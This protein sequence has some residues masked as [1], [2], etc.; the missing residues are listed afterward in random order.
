MNE[1]HFQLLLSQTETPYRA[2]ARAMVMLMAR[3]GLAAAEVA[4]ARASDF[5]PIMG[6]IQ[7]RGTTGVTPR[8]VALPRAV[9][10]AIQDYLARRQG[11]SPYLFTTDTTGAKTEPKTIR[12]TVRRLARRAGLPPVEAR[13]L[14]DYYAEC[15][16]STGADIDA[17]AEAMG[18]AEI[19]AASYVYRR[20]QQL[21]LAA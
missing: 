8:T 14:R 20:P 15:L 1:Y 13:D 3:A 16:L 11:G 5:C 21:A 10:V 19:Q 12:R 18:L 6:T 9:M 7:A 4:K 17:L 2:K